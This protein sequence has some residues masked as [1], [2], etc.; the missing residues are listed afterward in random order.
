LNANGDDKR[1]GFRPNT[2]PRLPR[3]PNQ[4][5]SNQ[6]NFQPNNVPQRPYQPNFQPLMQVQTQVCPP[7]Q[8]MPQHRYQQYQTPMRYYTNQPQFIPHPP[9]A[10]QNQ[11]AFQ[12]QT[13]F[14]FQ[15]RFVNNN[16]HEQLPMFNGNVVD[17]RFV[18]N[19]TT[20]KKSF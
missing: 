12:N 4:S 6:F 1:P 9:Y 17:K 15:P 18:Q 20:V 5:N 19:D 3:F 10:Q 7:M 14:N 16:A 11:F 13:P 2:G 8:Y